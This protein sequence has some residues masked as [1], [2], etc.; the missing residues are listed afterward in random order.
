ME[1][2]FHQQVY[3]LGFTTNSLADSV[4]LCFFKS[5]L[6]CFHCLGNAEGGSG[7]EEFEN[8]EEQ[9]SFMIFTLKG[10]FFANHFV[11][12]CCMLVVEAV[13]GL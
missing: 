10:L 7:G 12:D 9:C 4:V 13:G 5:E 3:H 2:S 11:R 6:F 8:I 1:H